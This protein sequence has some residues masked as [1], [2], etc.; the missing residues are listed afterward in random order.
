[1]IFPHEITTD[2]VKPFRANWKSGMTR[3]KAQQNL[4]GFLRPACDGKQLEDIF[5][6]MKSIKLTKED[7]VLTNCWAYP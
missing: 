6:V 2:D 4:R 7:N 5:R 1:M 3:Q